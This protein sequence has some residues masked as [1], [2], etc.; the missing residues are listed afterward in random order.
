MA[1]VGVPC[2]IR[3]VAVQVDV[4]ANALFRQATLRRLDKTL[5]DSLPRAI[6]GYDVVDAVAF[7][8]CI[9]GMRTDVEIQPGAV[10][11]EHVRRSTPADHTP[12][13]ISGD[14]VRRQSTLAA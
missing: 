6:V 1:P 14:L 8:G 10:L 4:P 2:R 7:R 3:V 12:E 5:K 11:K 13:K 9:F